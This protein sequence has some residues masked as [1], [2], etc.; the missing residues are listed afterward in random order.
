MPAERAAVDLPAPSLGPPRPASGPA[1]SVRF[2]GAD[3]REYDL[4]CLDVGLAF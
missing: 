2:A 3:G 1:V 4:W